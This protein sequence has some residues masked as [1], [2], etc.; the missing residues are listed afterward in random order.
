M[1]IAALI[2][3]TI[4]SNFVKSLQEILIYPDSCLENT[5]DYLEKIIENKSISL[6]ED[7]HGILLEEFKRMALRILGRSYMVEKREAVCLQRPFGH[8]GLTVV[9][10]PG[11]GHCL[12]NAVALHV[13]MDAHELRNIVA[14]EIEKNIEEYREIVAALNPDRTVAEYLADLRNNNEWAD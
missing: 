7:R 5:V 3:F 14:N 11:D 6:Q 10:L 12:F 4:P 13:G 9:K 8:M 1:L 2:E